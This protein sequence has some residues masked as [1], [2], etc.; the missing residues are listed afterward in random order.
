[1]RKEIRASNFELLR[2]CCMLMIIG[3]HIMM[4][5]RTLF[6]LYSID[7][8][9]SLFL[10]GAFAVAVNTFVL[11]SGYFGIKFKWLRFWKLDM[12]TLFYTIA[13]FVVAVL[14]GWHSIELKKDF[15][16]LFPILSK[17]YWFITCYAVLYLISP[18]LNQWSASLEKRKFRRL[19]VWG[20]FIIY[21]WP[22]IS[23]LFNATQFV[24]DAGFGIINF[25]YLY[26]L[27]QYLH[28]HYIDNYS[29]RIYWIGYLISVCLLFLAQYSLSYILG[30]NF[31]S[32]MSYNTIFVLAGSIFIFLAFKST[33][34]SS[35]WVNNLAKPCLAVYLIHFHP[36]I[37]GNFCELIGVSSFHGW[38][39]LLI[40]VFLPVIIY[41][42]CTIIE[43]ARVL[44][45][46]KVEDLFIVVVEKKLNAWCKSKGRVS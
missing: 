11:I 17:Q 28:R 26:M 14:I 31:T 37:W 34:F 43:Y 25:I 40:I 38:Q 32:W 4:I 3:G 41:L 27:G 12:Q 1:M 42:I 6:D 19:L 21:L 36:C 8:C 13:L 5:H 10:R 20:F 30:F 9:F 35:S 18:L 15:L 46:G 29:A 33:H 16:L 45:L 2:I 23:F 7:F 22:T 39:Y 44:A 24:D